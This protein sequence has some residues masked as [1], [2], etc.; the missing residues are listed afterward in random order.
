VA[1]ECPPSLAPNWLR[2]S[3]T[4]DMLTLRGLPCLLRMKRPPLD[5][6]TA[7]C[8]DVPVKREVVMRLIAVLI[9]CAF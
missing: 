5:R 1:P 2:Q 9:V 3:L 8:G 4:G 6:H 7:F